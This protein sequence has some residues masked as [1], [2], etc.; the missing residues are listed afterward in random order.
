MPNKDSFTFSDKLRKSKSVPLS[1]RLPSIVGG[2]NK[3]KRTLVQRAQRDLPFILV[4]ACALLLLPFLSRNGN[5]DITGPGNFD[6]NREG[7]EEPFIEG[8]GG[9]LEP[10]GGMQDP[11]DLILTPRSAVDEGTVTPGKPDRDVYGTRDRERT[12]YGTRRGYDDDY[13]NKTT[14]PPATTKFGKTARP[15]VRKSVER[16]PTKTRELRVSQVPTGRG[17]TSTSHSLPIG[18]APKS[19]PSGSTINPGV[20]PV[21]LQPM[22]AH[23]NVGRSMT[24]EN[25]YAEAARSIGAMNAGGSAK[26]NLLASQ[27]KD[28]DG[29]MSALGP[30]GAFGGAGSPRPGGAGGGPNNNNGYNIGKPWWWDMMQ[31]RSQKWWELFEYKWREMLWTNIYDIIFNGGKQIVN[32]L[33]FGNKEVDVSTM[34]GKSAGDSDWMC[35]K[36][37]KEVMPRYNKQKTHKTKDK[38]GNTTEET[39][40]SSWISECINIAG[41]EIIEKP[42]KDTGFFGVRAE[43]LGLD[44]LIDA[45]INS[46]KYS[47]DCS[48]V[49]ND[50]MEFSYTVTKKGEENERLEGKAEPDPQVRLGKRLRTGKPHLHPQ[51]PV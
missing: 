25:L 40:S 15:A 45:L 35:M 12:D 17:A 37:G 27:M 4:A 41:G 34:F 36:N 44:V 43:C 23:G 7:L 11:L 2:Q 39:V 47:G 16:T 13:R 48:K 21:A 9:T 51:R 38:D 10:T 42:K 31:A 3:Q 49:N 33:L 26:A 46:K 28:Q 20:R 30:A 18:Q 24:G 32:C 8:G 19:E 5:D 6:W 1:K 29:M 22:G 14:T 50:P